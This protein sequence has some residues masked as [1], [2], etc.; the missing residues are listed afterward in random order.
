M[1]NAVSSSDGSKRAFWWCDTLCVPLARE[2]VEL[3]A[4]AIGEMRQIYEE[5]ERVL[6]VDNRLMETPMHAPSL[7]LTM[8]LKLSGWMRRLWTLQEGI[9]AREICVQFR[10]GFRA[11]TGLRDAVQAT[12]LSDRRYRYLSHYNEAWTVVA[13]LTGE[14]AG[15]RRNLVT[16]A[17][18]TQ[19][20]AT[21]FRADEAVVLANVMGADPRPILAISAEDLDGRMTALIQSFDSF[22]VD[23]LFAPPPHLSRHG[24]RWA[25]SSFLNCFRGTTFRG[26]MRNDANGQLFCPSRPGLS[27][28]LPGVILGGGSL[29]QLRVGEAFVLTAG[30]GATATLYETQMFV[31]RRWT[32]VDGSDRLRKPALILAVPSVGQSGIHPGN[33]AALVD[34][35]EKQGDDGV[36]RC[37]HITAV[38]L[39]EV[40]R[41]TRQQKPVVEARFTSE[42]QKWLVY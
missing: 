36:L 33:M 35:W 18:L 7:E 19:W 25:P 32:N 28:A 41:G 21:S 16:L 34:V 22:P 14:L 38:E 20:R 23:V 5:A 3:Q 10:D 13:F 42:D 31:G 11:V 39:A 17:P 4:R 40:E 1:V 9:V 8:R 2:S 24:W 37:D 12:G 15:Q 29:D 6:V 30:D 27:C 26:S